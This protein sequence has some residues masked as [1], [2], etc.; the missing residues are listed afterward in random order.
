MR[1]SLYLQL[2]TLR[3]FSHYVI[4]SAQTSAWKKG[5][6]YDADRILIPKSNVAGWPWV[7]LAHITSLPFTNEG[8]RKRQ[9]VQ[10]QAGGSSRQEMKGVVWGDRKIWWRVAEWQE[11]GGE[12]DGRRGAEGYQWRV[13]A[14]H[15]AQC[16]CR[17]MP[18]YILSWRYV[19]SAADHYTDYRST[20]TTP[21]VWPFSWVCY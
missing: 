18:S 17:H 5:L 13:R 21:H 6:G 2:L 16:I 10:G 4:F 20:Q 9:P 12:G 19:N 15:A 1:F 14:R 8:R 3:H 11:V 7:P